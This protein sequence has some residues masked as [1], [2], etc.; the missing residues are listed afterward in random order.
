M[1]RQEAVT[2]PEGTIVWMLDPAT[3]ARRYFRFVELGTIGYATVT[4]GGNYGIPAEQLEV[5]TDGLHVWTVAVAP[6][7]KSKV[8]R[9]AA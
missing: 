2:V 3:K 7:S 9:G 4:T 1:T 6:A 8:K 5:P